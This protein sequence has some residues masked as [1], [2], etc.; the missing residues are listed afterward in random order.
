MFQNPELIIHKELYDLLFTD[1]DCTPLQLPYIHRKFRRDSNFNRVRCPGCNEGT[2]GSKEGLIDCPYCKGEGY[3]WDDVLIQG[4]MFDHSSSHN[5]SLGSPTEAG[6]KVEGYKKLVTLSN[7]FVRE[8]DYVYDPVLDEN[9]KIIFP[10]QLDRKF[11][12]TYSEKY[13]SNGSDSQYS[14]CHLRS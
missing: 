1:T 12:C 4:W 11:I 6:Y 13:T 3:L 7:H 10:I 8:K 2:S 9:H 5:T 14:L